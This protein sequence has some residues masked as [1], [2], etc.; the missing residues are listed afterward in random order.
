M[1]GN[2]HTRHE[3]HTPAICSPYCPTPPDSY[4][5]RRW[6]RKMKCG[7]AKA[8][9]TWLGSGGAFFLTEP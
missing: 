4:I 5:K 9:R 2:G 7:F 1:N 6:V 8:A 3:F